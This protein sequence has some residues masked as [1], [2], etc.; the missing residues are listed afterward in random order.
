M[1]IHRAFRQIFNYL[2]IVSVLAPLL[3]TLNNYVA[4]IDLKVT[5]RCTKK[6]LDYYLLISVLISQKLISV[7]RINC[8]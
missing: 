4:T 7:L 5:A 6:N 3:G 8:N 1:Y 2:L